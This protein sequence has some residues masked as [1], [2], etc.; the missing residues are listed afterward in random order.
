MRCAAE[1]TAKQ[2]MHA[3]SKN[4]WPLP[5][6]KRLEPITPERNRDQETVFKQQVRK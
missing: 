4:G 2:S 5:R 1:N 3:A 6:Y